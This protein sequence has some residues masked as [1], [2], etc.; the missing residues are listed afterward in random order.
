MVLVWRSSAMTFDS[1]IMM[2]NIPK[3]SHAGTLCCTALGFSTLPLPA[4]R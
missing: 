1:G 3:I 4:L 2:K